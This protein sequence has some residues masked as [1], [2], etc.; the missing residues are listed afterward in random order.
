MVLV[1]YF[2]QALVD[3]LAQNDHLEHIVVRIE[4]IDLS[5]ALA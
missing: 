2:V 1:R 4:T 5:R 3:L